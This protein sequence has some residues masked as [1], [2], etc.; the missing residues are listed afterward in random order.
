MATRILLS[1]GF[2]LIAILTAGCSNVEEL[3]YNTNCDEQKLLELEG[4]TLAIL[5]YEY[6][7]ALLVSG[8][9][10]EPSIAQIVADHQKAEFLSEFDSLFKIKGVSNDPSVL[11]GREL[12][13]DNPQLIREILRDVDA[14]GGILVTNAYGYKMTGTGGILDEAVDEYIGSIL[15]EEG[16]FR[17]LFEFMLGPTKV[18]AYFLASNTF[19]VDKEGETIWNFYGK[20]Y[21]MP[22]PSEIV[23]AF[24]PKEF[25]RGLF[26][27]DPSQ[28]RLAKAMMPISSYYTRYIRWLVQAD[29][30]GAPNKNYFTSYPKEKIT[31]Y[32]S[33]YPASDQSHLP[34]VKGTPGLPVAV[35]E[36]NLGLWDLAKSGTW[37]KFGERAQA[38]AA[39]KLMLIF[40]VPGAILL[41]IQERVGEE[42]CLGRLLTLPLLAASAS[43]LVAIYYILK[44]VL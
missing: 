7:D 43:S 38:W 2:V 23:K 44:A 13:I 32:I 29:L 20:V 41:T 39:F 14:D 22:A 36:E 5:S 25:V 16:L 4:R 8:E 9:P 31:Q 26:G 34:Y 17:R 37:G 33:V 35:G 1:V 15:P 3:Q 24:K 42:S 6:D 18:E 21:A 12:S 27:L 30:D 10:L 40:L 19:I 28:Q 11:K